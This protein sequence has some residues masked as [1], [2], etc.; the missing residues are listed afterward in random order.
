MLKD[1]SLSKGLGAAD[2]LFQ[3]KNEYDSNSKNASLNGRSKLQFIPCID[4]R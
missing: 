3:V 1:D 2:Q 4:H